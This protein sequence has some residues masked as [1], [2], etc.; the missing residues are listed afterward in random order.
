HARH[1]ATVTSDRAYKRLP[2][3]QRIEAKIAVSNPHRLSHLESDFFV[4]RFRR[5][6]MRERSVL[7]ASVTFVFFVIAGLAAKPTHAAAT[8]DCLSRPNSP[9]P[10]GQHWY[11]RIDHANNR[12]CWRLGR[13]GLRVQKSESKAEAVP[14]P[15]A[16]PAVPPQAQRPE[17]SG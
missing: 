6:R 14:A 2:D 16:R 17:T 12:Q 7:L 9:A 4:T 8:D 10:Q 11:Y 3:L 15:V 13:E 1:S 5:G